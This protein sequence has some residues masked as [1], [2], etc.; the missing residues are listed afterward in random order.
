[1]PCRS[2]ASLN[3]CL[4]VVVS[5]GINRLTSGAIGAASSLPPAA[6]K[7]AACAAEMLDMIEPSDAVS[8]HDESEFGKN[9]DALG[10]GLD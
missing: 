9:Q 4:A 6:V 2:S 3:F 5:P 10:A 1:M 7:A 8:M